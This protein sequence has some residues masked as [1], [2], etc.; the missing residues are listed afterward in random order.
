MHLRFRYIV[1]AQAAHEVVRGHAHGRL[2]QR[3]V[4]IREHGALGAERHVLLQHSHSLRAA[5]RLGDER[6]RHGTQ[7]A[8]AQHARAHALVAQ[9]PHHRAHQPGRRSQRDQYHIGIVAVQ[10]LDHAGILPTE[11]L[12]EPLLH[13]GDHSGRVQH[14]AM[15]PVLEVA[16]VLGTGRE[17]DVH[18]MLEVEPVARRLV[19]WQERVG[20]GGFGHVNRLVGVREREPV[21]VHHNGRCHRRVLGH[22]VRHER[23]VER[24]LVVFGVHLDPSMVEQRQRVALVAVDV[25]RQRGCAVRV[26]HHDGEPSARRVGQALGHVQQTLARRGR[27]RARTRS[28]RA[29]GA[30]QRRMLAFNVHVLGGQRAVLDHL[31]QSLHHHRLRCDGI[32]GNHLRARQ[33]HAFGERFVAGKEP[34][35]RASASLSRIIVIELNLHAFAQM[36]QPLQKSRSMATGAVGCMDAHA[37]SPSESASVSPVSEIV[38]MAEAKRAP[39][40]V[41]SGDTSVRE[42]SA[43][44]RDRVPGEAA[45]SAASVG[46]QAD[47]TLY[48][49]PSGQ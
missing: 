46:W 34:F 25:P 15:L 37:G 44:P 33:A 29:D 1:A 22:R 7:V 47:G 32:R 16:V 2:L 38:G 43:S 14:V 17:A 8:D 12:G 26:H 21:E 6:A 5:Q 13:L 24:L 3:G 31:A 20:L 18:G 28:R 23:Q 39:Q 10:R 9:L 36:P 41:P 35:H 48:T 49:V 40:E 45:A 19:G 4:H 30:R 27:E 11:H 42:P